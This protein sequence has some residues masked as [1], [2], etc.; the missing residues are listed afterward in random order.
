MTSTINSRQVLVEKLPNATFFVIIIG[1]TLVAAVLR[2]Y[3]LGHWSLWID[4]MITLNHAVNIVSKISPGTFVYGFLYGQS[5]STIFTGIAVHILG[6]EE[7]AARLVPA[8]I[9][10]LTVPM[11]G[12]LLR[13]WVGGR[14][15][16]LTSLFIALSPWHVY[17]SQ[18]VRYLVMQL[19][20]YTLLFFLIY[21]CWQLR[22]YYYLLI[23]GPLLFLLYL[24][25]LTGLGFVLMV[26]PLYFFMWWMWQ[27]EGQLRSM[28]TKRKLILLT[29]PAVLLLGAFIWRLSQDF[30][31]WQLLMD[32]RNHTMFS[33]LGEYFFSVRPLLFI[34]GLIGLVYVWRKFDKDHIW[35]LFSLA[36]VV[37]IIA[38]MV[39]SFVL[40]TGPRYMFPTLIFWL[41][42]AALTVVSLLDSK[43]RLVRLFGILLLII[44]CADSL[45]QLWHYHVLQE[46]PW[47][48]DW[49]GAFAY[50]DSQKSSDDIVITI[51]W[52]RP[53]AEYYLQEDSII[54]EDR[55][56]K[57]TK[58][59]VL[60]DSCI[61][62]GDDVVWFVLFEERIGPDLNAWLA[63]YQP[64]LVY[65]TT[66]VKVYR[67]EPDNTAVRH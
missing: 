14:V 19:L 18:N 63:R 17:W 2:L 8:V 42:M 27:P 15:A 7:W 13:N 12:V 60:D 32:K 44:F 25:R 49:K 47:R 40:F 51:D 28:L 30:Y 62:F 24:E 26:L 20:I 1:L 58:A 64:Q 10:I 39:A 36:A 23:I 55:D 6:T 50:V 3:Q 21:R 35:F 53:L 43:R 5:L 52:R 57:Y 54:F 11:A 65:E 22:Q 31:A 33:I 46:Q 37:P 56:L 48:P 59:D 16:L 61:D 45:N 41:A 4:E 34:L 38:I 29:A 9:G 67:Y 66:D